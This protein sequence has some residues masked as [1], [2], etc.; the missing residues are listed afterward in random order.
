MPSLVTLLRLRETLL[1]K[2]YVTAPY[3]IFFKSNRRVQAGGP[4]PHLGTLRARICVKE[5]TEPKD[6][7]NIE[8]INFI[9]GESPITSRATY[10]KGYDTFNTTSLSIRLSNH[11][12]TIDADDDT[13]LRRIKG[14]PFTNI[15]TTPEGSNRR[16]D[17]FP[18]VKNYLLSGSKFALSQNRAEIGEG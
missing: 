17:F 6:E 10:A 2:W 3:D 5:E 1:E 12:P 15:Y 11:K 8:M 16:F 4:S 14:V 18:L 9:S 7:L 13:M